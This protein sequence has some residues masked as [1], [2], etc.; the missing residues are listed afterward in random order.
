MRTL[1]SVVTDTFEEAHNED[2]LMAILPRIRERIQKVLPA[3]NACLE[4][5]EIEQIAGPFKSL[6]E[7]VLDDPKSQ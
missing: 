1:R 7:D 5:I 3:F 2:Q 4:C 6:S